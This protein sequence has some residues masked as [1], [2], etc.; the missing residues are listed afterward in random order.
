MRARGFRCA[1]REPQ[2]RGTALQLVGP[3]LHGQSL[4]R[5]ARDCL[6]RKKCDV[7]AP[8]GGSALNAPDFQRLLRESL[9]T[10]FNLCNPPV[11]ELAQ[12]LCDPKFGLLIKSL[13]GFEGII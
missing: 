6:H 9:R 8:C 13:L 4:S 7:G 5:D 12:F 3:V 11:I 1:S 2:Q 10:V